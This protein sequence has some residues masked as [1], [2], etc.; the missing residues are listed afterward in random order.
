[1]K[2]TQVLSGEHRVIEV[3]LDCLEQMIVRSRESNTL[4]RETAEQFVDFIRT[5]ADGCH[6]GKEENHLFTALE[7]K[8]ASRESG[9]VGVMLHE[10]QLGRGYVSQMTANIAAAAIGDEV[11]LQA[12]LLS[13]D[14]YV[15]LLRAHIL[16]EDQ[17][18]F[19]LADSLFSEEDH[20]RISAAFDHVESHH[21]GEGTHEKYLALAKS[22]A[23]RFGVKAD[24][25]H[26]QISCG[27]SHAKNRQTGAGSLA[28]STALANGEVI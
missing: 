20:V 16:K 19:P 24:A 3:V 28:E 17:I 8:G 7:S 1:M 11:A 21:M 15:Q 23:D 14:N 18:L 22:L 6:H 12:F 26:G 25:L 4:D 10:H 27:C 9:P 13:A 5:F 2:P